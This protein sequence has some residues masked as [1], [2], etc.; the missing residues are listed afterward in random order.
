MLAGNA[1]DGRLFRAGLALAAGEYRLSL[2][3]ERDRPADY[4]LSL[5]PSAPGPLQ[6]E[7]EPDDDPALA[8]LLQPGRALRGV[9]G[10]DNPAFLRFTV[11]LPGRLWEIRGVQGLVSLSLSDRKHQEIASYRAR[12]G[13]LVLRLALQPGPHL[14]RLAGEG[15]YALRLTDL[16]ARQPE[17][18]AEPNDSPE[19][20]MRLRPGSGITADLQAAGDTDFYEIDLPAP[21]PLTLTVTPPDD[22]ALPAELTLSET[23]STQTAIAPL[24]GPVSYTA[25]FPAGRQVLRL[26]APDAAAAAPPAPDARPEAARPEVSRT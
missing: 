16:G 8:R 14:I 10:P 9:L 23:G 11:D 19:T 7:G 22:G 1:L 15:P 5:A 17:D 3:G 21:L 4:R 12:D 26:G 24:T 13:S 18:E 20:A 6:P 25:L 2:A